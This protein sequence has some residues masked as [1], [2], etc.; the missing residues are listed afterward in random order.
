MSGVSVPAE[1]RQRF[2]RV[3]PYLSVPRCAVLSTIGL[4]GAPHPA[5][6]HYLVEED[7]LVI[8]GR[9]DRRWVVNLRRDGRVSI[10]V[11]DQEEPLHWVGIKGVAELLRDGPGAVADAMTLARRYNEDPASFQDQERVSFRVL[12]QRVDEYRS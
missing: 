12:P 8:N 1:T 6:V 3:R 2:D 4:D 5:V 11:H 10:V 9:V 7:A